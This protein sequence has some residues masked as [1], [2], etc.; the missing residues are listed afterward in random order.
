MIRKIVDFRKLNSDLLNRLVE[1]Y[2]DGYDDS[3]II[4]F[5]NANN[6]VVEAVEIKTEDTIYLIKVGTR[7]EKAMEDFSE[8]DLEFD[9]SQVDLEVNF[10][11]EDDS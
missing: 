3:D 11:D 8:R 4:S 1:K 5:R 9:D 10:E 7:L 2:P 6:E